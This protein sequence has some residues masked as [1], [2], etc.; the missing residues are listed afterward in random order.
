[1]DAP[2]SL[3]L[4][5]GVGS[6][7]SEFRPLLKAF[8]PNA[9]IVQYAWR[10]KSG[11]SDAAGAITS[12]IRAL[13]AQVDQAPQ[14]PVILLGHSFGAWLAFATALEMQRVG[15]PPA[16]VILLAAGHPDSI[17]PDSWPKTQADILAYWNDVSPGVLENLPD[18]EWQDIL[19][20]TSRRDFACMKHLADLKWE[21]LKSPIFAATGHQDP[22]VSQRQ[23]EDWKLLGALDF[24][25]RTFLGGHSDLLQTD[26]FLTWCH[27]AIEQMKELNYVSG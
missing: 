21:T 1:M 5:P 23:C 4:F 27:H 9:R 19:I 18:T 8:R 2:T 3:C 15:R 7:G 16:G 25:L 26:A 13:A 11:L 10:D 14:G 22:L 20:E 17:K 12:E 6:F 24:A